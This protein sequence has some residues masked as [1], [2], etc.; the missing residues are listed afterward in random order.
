[1][2]EEIRKRIID[3]IAEMTRLAGEYGTAAAEILATD[4]D[5]TLDGIIARRTAVIDAIAEARRDI[6]DACHECTE[7]ESDIVHGMIRGAHVPVGIP[8]ELEE[9]HKAAVRM[10]SVYISAAEKDKQ[11]SARVDARVKELRTELENVNTD[12]KKTAG[13]TAAGSG[14]GG[15][16][17]SFDGR[18]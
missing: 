6:D 9:I 5:E 8:S 18:L 15:S 13:Y 3:D 14:L 10:H 16:G 1:M 4:I 2:T 12:R 7:Q 17:R 11:A